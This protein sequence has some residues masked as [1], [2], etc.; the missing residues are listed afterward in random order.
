MIRHRMAPHGD[1]VISTY[2]DWCFWHDNTAE[3]VED[4]G[5]SFSSGLL[6]DDKAD[7]EAA[8][9]GICFHLMQQLGGR[10]Y[11]LGKQCNPLRIDDTSGAPVRPDQR[12]LWNG[13]IT[14]FRELLVCPPV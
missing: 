13:K 8:F 14:E 5:W 12:V 9:V 2:G 3:S 1:A 4:G 11:Y 7:S 6:P 10:L